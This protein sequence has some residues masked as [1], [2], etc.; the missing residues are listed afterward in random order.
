MEYGRFYE[1]L[2]FDLDR[3][4]NPYIPHNR[5]YILPRPLQRLLGYRTEPQEE[6]PTAIRWILTF[7]ATL[8]GLCLVAGTFTHAP[9]IAKYHPPVI[10]ASL[11]ASAIL[12]Y[13]AVRSPLAQPRN[14]IL[15]HTLSAIVGVCIAKLFQL[16][17]S[18]FADY[19]WVAGAV[20][21][22]CASLVMSITDTVHPPGGATAILASTEAQIIALGWMFIP[23][24]LLGSVL[25]TTVA[26][27]FNNTLRQY[28]MYWWTPQDVGRKLRD[29]RISEKTDVEEGAKLGKQVSIT[30]SER[31]LRHEFSNNIDFIDGAEDIHIMAYQL[32]MPTHIDLTQEEA[33]VIEKLQERIRMHAEVGG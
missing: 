11:G 23:L 9:G 18:F 8:G 16:N 31:T 14:A 17:P 22:A 33:A 29:S 7:V 27:L 26:L 2:S 32:R 25:M 4:L 5:L 21:C 24:V 13:N 15:G 3:H 19:G 20:G 6:P 10:V 1:R 12:D 30:E 28:P